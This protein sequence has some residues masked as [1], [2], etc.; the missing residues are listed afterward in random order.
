M[1]DIA[2]EITKIRK[3]LN[4]TQIQ[5]SKLIGIE[6]PY[7]SK[8][9]SGKNVPTL[10]TLIEIFTN[11][12][13]IMNI[14]VTKE[15]NTVENKKSYPT[16]ETITL[17]FRDEDPTEIKFNLYYRSLEYN[18]YEDDTFEYRYAL[19]KDEHFKSFLDYL[20]VPT[21]TPKKVLLYITKSSSGFTCYLRLITNSNQYKNASYVDVDLFPMS[22][23]DSDSLYNLNL[24]PIEEVE[25]TEDMVEKIEKEKTSYIG[26]EPELQQYN[27]HLDILYEKDVSFCFSPNTLNEKLEDIYQLFGDL[28][29]LNRLDVKKDY[30][31]RY[32]GK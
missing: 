6:Q 27:K 1:I 18:E 30:F 28:L 25:N 20:K 29:Y 2:K 16:S 22:I 24:E 17:V 14:T 4:L 5:F 15:E 7:L 10:E 32:Y 19:I 8:I 9:E 21:K 11:L 31:D 13:Y 23:H 3:E 26:Y 12:G